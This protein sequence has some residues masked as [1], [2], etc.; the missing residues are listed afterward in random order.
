MAY[1]RNTGLKLLDDLEAA[2]KRTFTTG[3]AMK[4]LGSGRKNTLATLGGLKRA[5]R[6]VS[7]TKGL[8]ALWHPSERKW[9]IH[10]LPILD[11][12]MRYRNSPYYVGLLSAADHY[13]VAH[14]KPQVLQ[15]IIPKQ[16]RFRKAEELAISFH[17]LKKF[18]F[19]GLS[20]IKTQSVMVIFSSPERTALDLFYFESVCGGFKNICLVIQNLISKLKPEDLEKMIDKYPYSSS[21]QKLGYMLENFNADRRLLRIVTKWARNKKLPNIALS[22]RLPKKGKVHQ[23]WHIIE[24]TKI[25]VEE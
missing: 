13:G 3:D 23:L 11:A 24:N 5:K 10:P 2:G 1:I 4:R 17:V 20:T 22:Y 15:V 14:H 12:L 6:I 9:G 18:P 25:E 7:L 16:I 19:E 21:I 8:Y